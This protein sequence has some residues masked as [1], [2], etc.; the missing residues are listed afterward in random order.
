M[1][2]DKEFEEL[3]DK[4]IAQAI[5]VPI[6]PEKVPEKFRILIPMAERWGVSEDGL[7]Y[8]ILRRA[9]DKELE[10]L[11]SRARSYITA[12]LDEWLAGPEAEG[13]DF[14]KE[15]IAFTCMHLAADEANIILRKR[16][17]LKI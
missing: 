1:S 17:S 4:L 6:D 15:Y 2:D 3:M 13:P 11:I 7:R 10:D 12:L 5:P 9:S 14:S 16:R 8:C